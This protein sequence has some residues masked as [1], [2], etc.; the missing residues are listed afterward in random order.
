M[1]P[2]TLRVLAGVLCVLFSWFLIFGDTSRM[3]LVMKIGSILATVYFGDHALTGGTIERMIVK[4]LGL[5]PAHVIPSTNGR[6]SEEVK[7]HS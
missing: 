3:S 1:H 7:S 4:L 2:I 5:K 6:R